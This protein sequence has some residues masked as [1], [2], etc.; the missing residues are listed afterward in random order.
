M[1]DLIDY[2]NTFRAPVNPFN[3]EPWPDNGSQR[4]FELTFLCGKLRD[5]L[6]AWANGAGNGAKFILSV[7]RRAEGLD[8]NDVYASFHPDSVLKALE[9][10]GSPQTFGEVA[11]VADK[12]NV[13][14]PTKIWNSLSSYVDINY[15]ALPNISGNEINDNVKAALNCIPNLIIHHTD[16][17]YKTLDDS[18]LNDILTA[19]PSARLQYR[20]ERLDCENFARVML[21]WLSSMG[22]GNLALGYVE[23]YCYDANN[24][25]IGAHA[26]NLAVMSDG[27]VLLIEPQSNRI[28]SR[29]YAIGPNATHNEVY[30]VEF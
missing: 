4:K 25:F 3:G 8:Q 27:R 30:Y 22:Y 11:A 23:I 5:D 1:S 9:G 2:L 6:N 15:D 13:I 14:N 21:G 12:L 19:C 24:T 16:A 17:S 10:F 7:V 28:V 18:T 26:L 20:A 29:D